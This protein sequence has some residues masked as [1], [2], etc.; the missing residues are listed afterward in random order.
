VGWGKTDI[1]P[2]VIGPISFDRGE[3]LCEPR[4]G[5]TLPCFL[6]LGS[7]EAGIAEHAIREV[8]RADGHEK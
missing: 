3:L 5:Y 1:H 6:G 7:V 4:T 2:Q 8:E